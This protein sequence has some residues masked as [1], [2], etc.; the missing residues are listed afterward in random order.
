MAITST[1]LGKSVT[2]RLA[3]NNLKYP[4]FSLALDAKKIKTKL[5]LN[6]K[7]TYELNIEHLKAH[8]SA[9]LSK[10]NKLT[11]KS[12][13]I[14]SRKLA[15]EAAGAVIIS[16]PSPK[17]SLNLS[18][19]PFPLSELNVVFPK[20][21]FEKA[22]GTGEF[23]MTFNNDEH[24]KI[25][26]KRL[27]LNTKKAGFNYRKIRFSNLNINARAGEKL[28]NNR[29]TLKKGSFILTKNTVTGLNVETDIN[30]KLMTTLFE[31][32]W[33]NYKTKG[34]LTIKNPL[35]QK[36]SL[37]LT[38]YSENLNATKLRDI[39][40]E[41]KYA[42]PPKEKRF[43]SAIQ[44]VSRVKNAIPKGFSFISGNIK[45]L[46]VSHKYFKS[47]DFYLSAKLKNFS[48]ILLS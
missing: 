8:M 35:S 43:H 26:V 2:T 36:K 28:K 5:P 32:K 12:S 45:A 9:A 25:N 18:A 22:V 20:T 19:K 46:A 24:D 33:N 37:N 15:L 47:K 27:S 30:S 16:T 38:A 44:W 40:L 4:E 1:V 6:L 48:G 11:I 7:K 29:F 10:E 34:I 42:L 3:I 17:Y 41:I 21:P 31:G 14:K 39:V 13:G 23:E